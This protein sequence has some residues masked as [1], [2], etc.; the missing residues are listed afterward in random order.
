MCFLCF[1]VYL[2]RDQCAAT[3][4]FIPLVFSNNLHSPLI[5]L[6]TSPYYTFVYISRIC[7]CV[8]TCVCLCICFSM[9]ICLYIS[10]DGCGF[11][12]VWVREYVCV[13][14]YLCVYLFRCMY[15]L[16]MIFC[17]CPL[18]TYGEIGAGDEN[19]WERKWE[20]V[21]KW[22]FL[23]YV[24][25]FRFLYIFYV[26]FWLFVYPCI[27]IVYLYRIYIFSSV[28]MYVYM[29]V[30]V[31]ICMYVYIYVYICIYIC[32]YVYIC[33]CMYVCV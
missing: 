31:C 8:C 11:M 12:S 16:P 22:M 7:V 23:T 20:V 24:C 3:Y 5:Y 28:Y 30:C 4:F 18:A 1:C 14:I 6:I 29:C 19:A 15:N 2:F 13:I 27:L 33:I 32:I 21:S 17:Y 26:F 9:S 25:L 10:L